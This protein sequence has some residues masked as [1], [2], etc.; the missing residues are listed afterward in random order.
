MDFIKSLFTGLNWQALALKAAAC[1]IAA[2]LLFGVGYHFGESSVVKPLAASI[3]NIAP[4]AAKAQS[5]KTSADAKA[6]QADSASRQDTDAKR[7]AAVA[8]IKKT[9]PALLPAPVTGASA[10]ICPVISPEAM[11]KLNDPD[12]IG[13]DAQ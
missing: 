11:D 5:D 3:A 9:E 8:A 6:N 7:D 1:V 10:S 2:G 12:I 13:K 4:A